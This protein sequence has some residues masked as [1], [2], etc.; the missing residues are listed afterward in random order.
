[1]FAHPNFKI[2]TSP[3]KFSI[4]TENNIKPKN[5]LA[6][7]NFSNKKFPLNYLSNF[8]AAQTNKLNKVIFKKGLIKN[9]NKVI[10]ISG[11]IHVNKNL[12]FSNP[13]KIYPGTQFLMSE[14]SHIIFKNKFKLRIINGIIN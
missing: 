7:S 14:G 12:V 3:T 2:E 8:E 6:Q 9:K 4:I 1:M 11:I 5:I 10:K 13:V